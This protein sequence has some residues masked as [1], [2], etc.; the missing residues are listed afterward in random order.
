MSS[1]PGLFQRNVLRAYLDHAGIIFVVIGSDERVLLINKSGWEMLGYPNEKSVLGK[2][3]ISHFI[4][5]RQRRFVRRIFR[6]LVVG[7]RQPE[8]GPVENLILTRQG[9]LRLIRWH[10]TVLREGRQIVATVSTGT[11]ITEQKAAEQE[12]QVHRSRL[13]AIIENAQEPI[14]IKDRRYRYVLVNPAVERT[15]KIPASKLI[16]KTDFMLFGKKVAEP[17]RSI[18]EQVMRGKSVCHEYIDNITTPGETRYF[19]FSKFPL[20]DAQRN[21][22]GICGIVRDIT[23]Q[24]CVELSLRDSEKN[25]RVLAEEMTDGIVVAIDG[26]YY[27][28]NDAYCSIFG[29]RRKDLL[30]KKLD[31]IA[32]PKDA[33]KIRESMCGCVSLKT[34]PAVCEVQARKKDGSLITVSM[35]AI[36]IIFDHRQA[37]LVR[38]TDI[39]KHKKVEQLQ[40]EYQQ[41]LQ[42]SEKQA[43]EFSRGMLRVRER[44][45]KQIAVNL[46]DEIGG[47]VMGLGA[48]LNLSEQELSRGHFQKAQE[49]IR[50]TKK[51]LHTVAARIRRIAHD[52]TPVTLELVGLS[53]SLR[54]LFNDFKKSSGINGI[55]EIALDETA[56]PQENRIVI[57]RVAQEALHNIARHARAQKASFLCRQTKRRVEIVV[58]DNGKGFQ[59]QKVMARGLDFSMGLHGMRTRVESVQGHFFV[60][61]MPGK[62]TR[63][64]V[65]IPVREE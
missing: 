18:D 32:V 54:E 60:D 38:V 26:K 13:N 33:A 64:R 53:A 51:Y 20:Y 65:S 57:Y 46:H 31:F 7:A 15:L 21:I 17:V 36:K 49:H 59:V 24:K 44:E 2:N 28:I 16:G 35:Q 56:I 8:K 29:Y 55:C 52:L 50:K 48:Q 3:W 25:F 6:D 22:T 47:L 34:G 43:K 61:S 62:G 63:V 37:L 12:L 4:P 11:D 42:Y 9:K 5:Y 10:N 23:D 45:H 14:F 40:K 58:K 1:T 19:S 27:W 41:L 39:T 30:G